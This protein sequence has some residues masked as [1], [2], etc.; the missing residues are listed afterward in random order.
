MKICA[1]KLFDNETTYIGNVWHI[2]EDED[3][4]S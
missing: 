4:T 1:K 2:V 3:H